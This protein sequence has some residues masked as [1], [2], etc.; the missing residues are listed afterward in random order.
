MEPMPAHIHVMPG[1]Q[2]AAEIEP[3][4]AVTR[5]EEL[6][7]KIREQDLII[8]SQIDKIN[9]LEE[10]L[11]GH[12]VAGRM[13]PE[14]N[15]LTMSERFALTCRINDLTIANHA[16]EIQLL[17]ALNCLKVEVASCKQQSD[18]TD[19]ALGRLALDVA[20]GL[21]RIVDLEKTEHVHLSNN[22]IINKIRAERIR[23]Y[24]N[25]NGTP[26]K[27]LDRR[28]RKL[29]EGRAVRFELL[30]SYLKCDKFQ[31]NRALR[32]LFQEYPGEY[33]KK[34]LNKTTWLLVERPKL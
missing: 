1:F 10:M 11:Q 25:E 16:I 15:P 2:L 4:P 13:Q 24:L 34:R 28:T 19:G 12:Q 33:C 26:G 21:R 20:Q 9:E 23:E 27:F 3:Q 6:G 31:L 18:N 29:V 14:H 8:A 22:S 17:E 30:R 7:A 32:T 5:E